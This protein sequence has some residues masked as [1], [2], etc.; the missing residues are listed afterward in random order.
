M[1]A[2]QEMRSVDPR[3]YALGN[4][5]PHRAPHRKIFPLGARRCRIYQRPASV[6]ESGGRTPRK[7]LLELKPASPHWI[8]PLLR[9]TASDDPFAR[10]RLIFAT[11]SAAID[12]A[13]RHGLDY[14]IID[15]PAAGRSAS[16]QRARGGARADIGRPAERIARTQRLN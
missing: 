10:V 13:E 8:E 11:R 3:R 5:P 7:W 1:L 9:W 14:E 15:P 6:M 2:T 4:A 16:L 12:Y